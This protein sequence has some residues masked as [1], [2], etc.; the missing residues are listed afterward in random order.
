MFA[1]RHFAETEDFNDFTEKKRRSKITQKKVQNSVILE[2]ILSDIL[3]YISGSTNSTKI[4]QLC[5][6]SY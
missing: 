3:S 5:I 4:Y 1:W 6:G 2:S